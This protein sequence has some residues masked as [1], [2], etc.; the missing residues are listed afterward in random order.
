VEQPVHA[1]PTKITPRK[2]LA[3]KIKKKKKSPAKKVNSPT[4]KGEK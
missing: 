2:K 1:A 3:T 4:K